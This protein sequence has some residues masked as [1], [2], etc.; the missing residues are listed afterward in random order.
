M[1]ERLCVLSLRP[2][3]RTQDAARI[4]RGGAGYRVVQVQRVA[5]CGRCVDPGVHAADDRVVDDG[6]GD[7]GF[8]LSI[9][10]TTDPTQSSFLVAN[11]DEY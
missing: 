11:G 3:I 1:L 7:A 4:W 5:A 2:V 10:K 8:Y 6:V 9:I